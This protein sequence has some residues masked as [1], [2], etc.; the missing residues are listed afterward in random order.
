MSYDITLSLLYEQRK[1]T[2]ALCKE[3]IDRN[4]NQSKDLSR[5]GI[6]GFTLEQYES[7]KK[8]L[9]I[10]IQLA[11]LSSSPTQNAE[12]RLE[13][14]VSKISLKLIREDL[15]KGNRSP[16]EDD[17]QTIDSLAQKTLEKF[18]DALPIS[19]KKIS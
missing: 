17:Y 8:T 1:N 14:S 18:R 10:A 3:L 2:T 13:L 5:N 11:A 16:N 4:I 15:I 19:G 9:E 7:A 6:L 12:S